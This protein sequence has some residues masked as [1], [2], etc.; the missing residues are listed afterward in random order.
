MLVADTLAIFLCPPPPT[1]LPGDLQISASF[2][3]LL[4]PPWRHWK[5]RSRRGSSTKSTATAQHSILRQ[6]SNS[7]RGIVP[8]SRFVNLEHWWGRGCSTRMWRF[9]WLSG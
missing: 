5:S 2:L 1:T 4:R 7:D 3:T 6:A 9:L 8:D